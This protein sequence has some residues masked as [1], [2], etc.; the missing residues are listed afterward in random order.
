ME[1]IKIK[2]VSA[3]TDL[4]L[5]ATGLTFGFLPLFILFGIMG[6][7]GMEALTWNEESV[8]GIKA[9]FIGP[10]M[11]LFMSTVYYLNK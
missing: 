4:K 5:I 6:A 7:F 1:T 9:I 10:L 8:T 11:T 3:G 2:K